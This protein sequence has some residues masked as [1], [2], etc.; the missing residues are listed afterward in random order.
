MI[1]ELIKFFLYFVFWSFFLPV[2]IF[3]MSVPH[4]CN[5][6]RFPIPPPK[7]NNIFLYFFFMDDFIVFFAGQDFLDECASLSILRALEIVWT[8]LPCSFILLLK[9][10][11][12]FSALEMIT[13]VLMVLWSFRSC[14]ATMDTILA[15]SS[16][17]TQTWRICLSHSCEF[18]VPLT[19]SLCWCSVAAGNIY[20]KKSFLS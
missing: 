17:W 13:N 10:N 11:S 2:K 18:N 19:V 12:D 7:Q 1:Y 3:L 4:A 15:V 9:I 5:G 16:F 20:F 14:S 8:C 6:I